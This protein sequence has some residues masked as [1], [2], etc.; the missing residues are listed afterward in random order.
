MF[1]FC[2]GVQ[3]YYS[4]NSE[5]HYT[6]HRGMLIEGTHFSAIFVKWGRT[7][8]ER[9]LNITLSRWDLAYVLKNLDKRGRTIMVKCFH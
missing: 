2:L 3:L 6:I 1:S 5:S 7:I 8:Q 9:V 4:N